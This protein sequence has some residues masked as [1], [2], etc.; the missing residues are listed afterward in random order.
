VTSIGPGPES[1]DVQLYAPAPTGARWDRSSW[2]GAPWVAAAWQ[3][4]D[5]D[6]VEAAFVAGVTDEAG[7]LSQSAAGPMDL[8]TLDPNRE[9]DPSNADGPY[10][11]SIAPGTPLRLLGGSG[12]ATGVW[13]GFVDE[14]SYDVA[15]QR[16]RVRCV[17]AIAILAQASVPDGTVLP[18]TLRARV[19]AVVAAAGLADVVPVQPESVAVQLAVDPGFE[20]V[21]VL[22]GVGSF[23]DPA[24]PGWSTATGASIAFGGAPDGARVAR[25]T[26]NGS[27]YPAITSTTVGVV[28]GRTYRLTASAKRASGTLN[29][30]VRVDY[31]KGTVAGAS[32][33]VLDF[34][35]AA[36]VARSSS[37][38]VPTDGTVDGIRVLCH[39]NAPAVAAPDAWDFDAVTVEDV[40]DLP[41]VWTPSGTVGV[42]SQTIAPPTLIE[43]R[44]ALRIVG[45]GA[46]PRYAQQIVPA[47]GQTYVVSGWTSRPAGALFGSIGYIARNA[48]NAQ[49]ATALATGAD[50]SGTWEYLSTSY[51]T[52]ADGS[53]VR[54]DAIAQINAA[55]TAATDAPLFDDLRLTGP[56][57]ATILSTDPP[58]APHDGKA[59]SA[60][61]II[62]NAALDALTLVWL[63]PAGELRFTSWGS[64]PDAVISI[65]CPPA[66]EPADRWI[67]GLS[68]IAY[69]MS[70]AAIRN[71][72]RAWS[73]PSVW[74]PYVDDGPSLIRYGARP[75]DVD[76]V[77][78]DFAN[79]SARI[80]AD[81]AD[82]GLAVT[83]GEV[84][85][86]SA[87][88]LDALLA[89][90][91]AGP[92]IVRIADSEHGTPIDQDV[93]IVGTSG[94]M[95]PAGW[96]FRY[97]TMIPRA[98]WDAV[99][100]PAPKPPDPPVQPYHTET[101]TYVA[102]SD[103][104]LALTS[105]GSK[106]GAGAANSLPVGVWSGWT[107]RS[108]IQLPAIPWTKV[109][110]IVS[111]KLRVRTSTQV[112]VGFG[113]SPTIEVQ[114]ITGS[115]SAGSSTTPSSGN[116][117]VYPGPSTTSTGAKRANLT[118]SE[119]ADQDIDITAIATAWAP[120]SIGGSS[121]AQR[122]V[123]LL[124]GSGSGADTSE[125]W[126]VEASAGKPSLILVVEV[127]D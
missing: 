50:P 105:G 97:V 68:T 92:Q 34:T 57:A 109:R 107:Y 43:G 82:A 64:L 45:G 54:I 52:P 67:G 117:V 4:V 114:R 126:P 20:A 35:T 120:S 46:S 5:C 63:S 16:G 103:A 66:G 119:Q 125:L 3:S 72:V 89:I 10:F 51:T 91:T 39:V 33:A 95:T 37:F 80:L 36:F 87:S 48:A 88:E 62:Q 69:G 90:R 7:V 59:A 96:T 73:A 13:S 65:G 111:A 22:A 93:G 28:P 32:P 53:V 81:R 27:N 100:P 1:V 127:F 29:G 15:S 115:W 70:A 102:T 108:C 124:P 61:T 31:M 25:I 94:R 26:G 58:V 74:A 85:P 112:R 9:L 38:T 84:R 55:T 18:N 106:Y 99:E 83:L 77:V 56:T 78:P 23:E 44:R 17:D 19:R 76:R 86:Y 118:K 11:G 6:V 101:R 12:A 98:D 42:G 30:R 110:R 113:S 14:A 123:M 75:L 116:A 21:D 8:A 79:W 41:G 40:S 104:L 49:I 2:D 24:L 71:R 60:W 122:G 47:A 121:A